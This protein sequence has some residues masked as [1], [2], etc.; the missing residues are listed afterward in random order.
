MWDGR[1]RSTSDS[2]PPFPVFSFNRLAGEP[3]RV[4]WPLAGFQDLGG[5]GFLGQIDPGRIEWDARQPRLVWRGGTGGRNRGTGPGR[6]EGMRLISAIRRFQ[7]GKLGRRKME[8]VIR[9]GHRWQV[10]DRFRDDPRFDLGF[11]DSTD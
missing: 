9:G 1:I 2:V 4:L 10:L 8:R 11:V 7:A 3:G 6:G 5:R